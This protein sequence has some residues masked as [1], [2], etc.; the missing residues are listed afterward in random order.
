MF[1]GSLCLN[2]LNYLH[3]LHHVSTGI[4]PVLNLR[5]SALFTTVMWDPPST[6]GLLSNLYYQVTLMNNVSNELIL[7]KTTDNT[8][9]PL[10]NVQ[11][12]Q[13][14]TANVTAFSS[15]YHGDGMV[16]KQRTPGGVC[17]RACV[18]V[19]VRVCVRAC[20]HACTLLFICVILADQHMF[21]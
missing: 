15:K 9:Y 1:F 19:C 14:Y 18:C 11:R 10:P 6:A 8:Y 16:N 20:V 21:S 4:G 3:I 17:V 5:F 7:N 12:C 2:C 13:Y